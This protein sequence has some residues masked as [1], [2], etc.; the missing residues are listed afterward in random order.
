MSIWYLIYCM[1]FK[2]RI[3]ITAFNTGTSLNLTHQTLLMWVKQICNGH[4]LQCEFSSFS[5][6]T[7]KRFEA[8]VISFSRLINRAISKYSEWPSCFYYFGFKRELLHVPLSA[9]HFF[10]GKKKVMKERRKLYNMMLTLPFRAWILITFRKLWNVISIKL[11]SVS[12][13]LHTEHQ[14]QDN[15]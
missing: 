8:F 2:W 4:I 9:Q 10:E 14:S 15:T 12:T 13:T 7:I 6:K 1:A 11:R 5:T 3:L